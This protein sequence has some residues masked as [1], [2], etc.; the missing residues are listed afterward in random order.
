MTARI[1]TRALCS[2]LGATASWGLAAPLALRAED[3]VDGVTAVSGRVSKEYVRQK[4]PDGSFRPEAYAFGDGGRY[5]GTFRD[6][7]IDKLSFLEIARMISVPLRSQNYVPATDVK[8][9][10]LMIMVHWGTTDTPDSFSTT[11]GS[12]Q[13]LGAADAAMRFGSNSNQ[14][15]NATLLA[16]RSQA[17]ENLQRD[18]IDYQNAKLLG[19]D[20]EGLIGTDFGNWA[21]HTGWIG[22]HKDELTG[23]IEDNRFFVVLIAYDF[24]QYRKKGTLKALWET[25][26]SINEPHNSFDKALP[27]MATYASRYFGQDSH[28]LVRTNVPDGNVKVGEPRSLGT[29]E[30]K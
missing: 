21:E 11:P 12:L 22:L 29:V 6:P 4:L 25:R 2:L 18:R 3:A 27:V 20:S 1:P 8:T 17:V 23:E 16:E 15:K 10:K 9:E 14:A 30:G 26:F 5:N 19:Y 28:G 13:Q 7:S 24:Q